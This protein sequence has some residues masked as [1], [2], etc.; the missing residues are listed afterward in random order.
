MAQFKPVTSQP[1]WP[2]LEREVLAFWRETDAFQKRIQLNQD[3][4]RWRFL[5]G[6]ITANNPMGVHHAWG[7]T[8]KDAWQR[9]KAMQ[10][11]DQRYQNGFD[12]QGL[13]VEVEVEKELGFQSKRDIEAHGMAAFVRRCKERV[14]RYAAVQTEQS[15]RLGM[16]MHWDDPATLR[17]LARRAARSRT[18]STVE[19][20]EG[21]MTASPERLV[22]P[23]GARA[24]ARQ[25]LHVLAT[26]TTTCIWHFLKTL[27][28]AGLDLPG[29]RRH[30][31]VRPLRHGPVAARDR[32]RGLPGADPPGAHRPLPAAVARRAAARR[33]SRPTAAS[34]GPPRPGR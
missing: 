26:R 14:L 19:T 32:H 29:H 28:R 5:D 25:L 3:G 23:A 13:W 11:F 12:C 30:A 31:L 34:S 8:Y 24:V 18:R 16:W 6:P 4:P 10:G 15:I 33:P 22:E 27:P 7:R 17:R 1:D 9:F 21:P 20:A 2:A